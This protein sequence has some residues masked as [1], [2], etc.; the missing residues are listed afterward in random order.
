MP[1]KLRKEEYKWA[2]ATVGHDCSIG[3]VHNRDT[4]VDDCVV[5]AEAKHSCTH[6][7]EP[8]HAWGTG[9]FVH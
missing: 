6:G 8:A 5:G 3:R 9:L 2:H 7:C 4:V 1:S